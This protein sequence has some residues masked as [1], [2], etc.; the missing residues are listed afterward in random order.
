MEEKQNQGLRGARILIVED[1]Y[2]LAED[3]ADALTDRGVEVLGPVGTIE[4][5]SQA[6]SRADFDCAIV[7]MNLRGDMA[8]PI[9]DQLG[10]AG[11][12]FLIATGYNSAS[13]PD[14]FAHVPR[15]EKPS[16]PAAIIDAVSPLL[17]RRQ[18]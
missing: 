2:Y 7:D 11:I 18:H 5:A 1:E 15:V 14:R 6:V 17:G 16:D 3:I 9:A 10:Q 8:F 12:P 4:E 13:L